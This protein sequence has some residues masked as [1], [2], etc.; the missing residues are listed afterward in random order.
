MSKAAHSY[1]KALFQLAS[2]EQVLESVKHDFKEL[3]AVIEADIDIKEFLFFSNLDKSEKKK[4]LKEALSDKTP[5]VFLNFLQLL[6]DHDYVSGLKEIFYFFKLDVNEFLGRTEG[7]IQ[8][9]FPLEDGQAARAAEVFSQRLGKTVELAFE[10]NP[11]LIGGFRVELEGRVYDNSIAM[12]L[13]R[14]KKQLMEE[15]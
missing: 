3:L 14:L 4:V 11:S 10:L 8:S 7:I 1:A 9:P 5:V 6:I 13:R 2:E 12:Q 15:K